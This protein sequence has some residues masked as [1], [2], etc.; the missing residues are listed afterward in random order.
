M[1]VFAKNNAIPTNCEIFYM[2]TSYK[3]ADLYKFVVVVV[4]VIYT[5]YIKWKFMVYIITAAA[6]SM[7]MRIYSSYNI[8]EMLTFIKLRLKT[9]T[10]FIFEVKS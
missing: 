6:Y 8:V 5:F 10:N 3:F 7:Y 1:C 9:E 4:V 2:C